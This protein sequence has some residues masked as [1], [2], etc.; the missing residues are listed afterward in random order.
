MAL[1]ITSSTSISRFEASRDQT[2]KAVGSTR[3]HST[4]VNYSRRQYSVKPL[5]AESKRNDSIVPLAAT[6]VAPEVAEKVEAEDYEKL[7]KEL[8]NASPL[9]IMD[10]ALEKFGNDIA[11]AFSGA[12]DVA[13]I[14]YAHL[15]GRPFRVF[16]LDTG[17]LNPET[18]KFFDTVEKNS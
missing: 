18:Y 4:I 9:E 6:M 3:S 16:S 17:R 10:K 11:I 2:A 8:Q 1:A 7:A 5:N 14:E 12:E 13:L 15:T